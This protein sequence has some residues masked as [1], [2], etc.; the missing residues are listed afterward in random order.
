[1]ANKLIIPTCIIDPTDERV[2]WSIESLGFTPLQKVLKFIE[3]NNLEAKLTILDIDNM[4]R[5]WSAVY[6]SW[7]C[8]KHNKKEREE[9]YAFTRT[10]EKGFCKYCIVEKDIEK[11]IKY[12]N[13]KESTKLLTFPNLFKELCD[14]ADNILAGF[15]LN[16]TCK[17]EKH[18]IFN[19]NYKL[20]PYDFNCVKCQFELFLEDA[21][22][23]KRLFK[24]DKEDITIEDAKKILNLAE[25]KGNVLNFKENSSANVIYYTNGY[26]RYD[27][28]YSVEVLNGIRLTQVE[29]DRLGDIVLL[30][31]SSVKNYNRNTEEFAQLCLDN[32]KKDAFYV[33]HIFREAKNN[34]L[35][36]TATC[37]ICE[38]TQ[39]HFLTSWPAHINCSHGDE[40]NRSKGENSIYTYLKL[41]DI[42]FIEQ[43]SIY[44]K[45]A[46]RID[47][48]LP[49]FNLFIEYNGKQH[50]EYVQYFHR[51]PEGFLDQQR[52]DNLKAEYC[53]KEG[54]KLIVIDGR[55]FDT[56]EKIENELNKNLEKH[57]IYPK[58]KKLTKSYVNFDEFGEE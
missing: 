48:Y 20:F 45:G 16:I 24:Y 57:G 3:Y 52:R 40:S 27:N 21:K 46:F 54:I 5:S 12:L 30:K 18:G 25:I 56:P 47:F 49:K 11:A 39:T 35:T 7:C 37:S 23:R 9:I 17:C 44:N 13:S 10:L 28:T 32:L 19:V 43:F 1:M 22:K 38:I 36:V 26:S 51:T 4:P 41:R 33:E 8:K 14:V 55:V 50:Y 31:Q 6:I 58:P 42:T 53:K 29:I 34:K 2:D 15:M